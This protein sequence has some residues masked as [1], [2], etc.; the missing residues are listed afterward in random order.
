MRLLPNSFDS[1]QG[2]I[3]YVKDL[4]PWAEGQA[5]NIVGGFAEAEARLSAIAP[6][7][8]AGTRNFGDGHVTKL[9]PY[10]RHGIVSLNEVRNRALQLCNEPGQI[11]K[12][13]QELAWRDFWHRVLAAHPD[14]SWQDVEPYK[15]GYK[16]S[17]YAD[18]L[19]TDIEQGKTGV[20]CLDEFIDELLSTG[21]IHNHARMYLASYV[22]HFRRVKW[23]AGASWFL[24]HLLD[25]DIAS[26][27]LSWQWVASTFSNKP[28]IF[29]LENVT[30]YFSK[31]VDV[32]SINNQAIDSSYEQLNQRLFPTK[33][34][35]HA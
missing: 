30:K 26:N 4:C 18:T 33:E 8:Y 19:P 23:Q 28:Y 22:V 5:S 27:N 12:F 13:I 3:D 6:I 21:Y 11:T 9:S 25:G 35:N 14:W 16:R 15:T 29:N 1:R 31:L 7:E 34:L 17:D 20:A 2:L 10:I 32:S 24:K